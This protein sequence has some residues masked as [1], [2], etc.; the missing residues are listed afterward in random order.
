MHIVSK[1][2]CKYYEITGTCTDLVFYL[3]VLVNI[4]KIIHKLCFHSKMEVHK[5]RSIRLTINKLQEG[6][7]NV[8]MENKLI[9]KAES[10][11]VII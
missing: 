3:S 11:T 9:K 7:Q 5:H 4:A 10:N 1:I 8:L 2:F 6:I